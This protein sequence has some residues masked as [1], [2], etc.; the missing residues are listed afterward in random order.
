MYYINACS[1]I[2]H[3]NSFQN[4]RWVNDLKK[5][6]ADHDLIT[7][8]YKD[9]IAASALRR[10]SN[11]IRMG[12]ACSKDAIQQAGIETPDAIIVGTGLGCL[13][14]TEKFLNNTLTIEGLIPPTSFIQSTHNTIAGQ[15]SLALKNHNYNITHTQNTLSFEHALIDAMLCLNE[16]DSNILIGAADEAIP[17]LDEL[18]EQFGLQEIR[19]KITTGASFFILSNQKQETSK[20]LLVDTD[21][22]GLNKKN[23][24]EL[25]DSFLEKNRLTVSD[26]DLVLWNSNGTISKNN[27]EQQF[28]GVNLFSYEDYCGYYFSNAAFGM[29]LASEILSIKEFTFDDKIK[30]DINRILLFNNFNNSNIGLTLLQSLEA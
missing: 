9:F 4:E 24:S 15:I 7:P 13:T 22:A 26:I 21:T 12:L 29:H 18:A 8:N 28:N 5:L 11:I 10:M 30:K 2:S 19:E 23:P 3:Q 6:C 1:T 17:L 25:I 14:D 16:E 20:A 27:I